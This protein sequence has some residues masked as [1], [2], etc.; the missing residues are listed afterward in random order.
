MSS[1]S[2]NVPVRSG[3]LAAGASAL[4]SLLSSHTATA[5]EWYVQ[6]NATLQ[7][8]YSTNVE[9]SPIAGQQPNSAGYSADAGS[10]IGAITPTSQ[11]LI[12][13]DIRYQYYPSDHSLDRLEAFLDLRSAF[14][15]E[16]DRFT[17]L[18]RFDRKDDLSAEIPEAQF[19]SVNPEV[20]NSPATG[21]VSPGVV[22]NYFYLLP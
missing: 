1:S 17:F 7:G 13:P 5:A 16:R 9:L 10:I 11:T 18:G 4:C 8:S 2:R 6:P 20:P 3:G 14:T 22:R 15:Y 12:R 19:N 21:H